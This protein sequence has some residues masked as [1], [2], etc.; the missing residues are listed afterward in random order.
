M[1]ETFDGGLGKCEGSGCLGPEDSKGLR[2]IDQVGR[3]QGDLR[4]GGNEK[5]VH[6]GEG[7]ASHSEDS[8]LD[9]GMTPLGLCLA[10]FGWDKPPHTH[11]SPLPT[12]LL[13]SPGHLSWKES[14]NEPTSEASL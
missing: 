3:P 5:G 1:R 2:A 14:C 8:I 4:S 6:P 10:R 9:V 11:L 12:T 7:E 13:T